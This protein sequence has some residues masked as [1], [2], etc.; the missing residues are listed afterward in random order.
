LCGKEGTG[1]SAEP[2]G[3]VEAVNVDF[4][5]FGAVVAKQAAQ[6]EAALGNRFEHSFDGEVARQAIALLGD[7][8]KEAVELQNVGWRVGHSAKR[9]CDAGGDALLDN[10][11]ALCGR[12]K[13]V[14]QALAT[15]FSFS[16]GLLELLTPG[17]GCA[18]VRAKV[19]VGLVRGQEGDGFGTNRE[20]PG[21]DGVFKLVVALFGGEVVEAV[22]GASDSAFLG[23]D[24]H[25]CPLGKAE[26]LVPLHV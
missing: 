3:V 13:G 25:A 22:K 18:D 7:A 9:V 11:K 4:A 12:S 10:A 24:G 17:Q 8:G 1:D 16:Q 14:G 20:G 5:S 6:A 2:A 19:F 26:H 15:F 23:V 21:C